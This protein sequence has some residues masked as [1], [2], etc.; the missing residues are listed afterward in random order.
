MVYWNDETLADVDPNTLESEK[1][2]IPKAFKT[3][4]KKLKLLIKESK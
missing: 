4:V 2:F 3:K 1:K